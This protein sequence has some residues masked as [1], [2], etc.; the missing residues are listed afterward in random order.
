MASNL[1]RFTIRIDPE[2]LKKIRYVAEY[3]AR[4]TNREVEVLIRNHV[5]NFEKQHGKIK[6]D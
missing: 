2:L 6:F 5:N 3:N 4:S 1:P